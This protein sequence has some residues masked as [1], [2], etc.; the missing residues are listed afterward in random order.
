MHSF[1]GKY[2]S[3]IVDGQ[4]Q[5][6]NKNYILSVILPINELN[7]VFCLNIIL[8]C[9]YELKIYLFEYLCID[10]AIEKWL[11]I[12]FLSISIEYEK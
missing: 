5:F 6:Y 11:D 1:I 4:G 12:K 9:E 8:F 7:S 3:N 2:W 10:I